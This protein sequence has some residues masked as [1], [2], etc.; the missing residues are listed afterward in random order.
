MMLTILAQPAFA[1]STVMESRADGLEIVSQSIEDD[2]FYYN[3]Y[4]TLDGKTTLY[5]EYGE[6][7]GENY[8][9]VSNSVEIN[10]NKQPDLSTERTEK[11]LIPISVPTDIAQARAGDCIYRPHHETFSF[12]V[13]KWTLG[14]LTTALCAAIGLAGGDAGVIAA[15]LIQYVADGI[16][17]EIPDSVYFQGSICN[18]YPVGKVYYRYKGNFYTDST[19]SH[20]L[21]ENVHWSRRWGH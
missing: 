4:L 3:Y 8:V 17:D 10:Q 1:L 19:R 2:S 20:L 18:S 16:I 21:A 9:L 6:R 12:K 5:T 7:V 13:E 11:Y 15:A 14:L